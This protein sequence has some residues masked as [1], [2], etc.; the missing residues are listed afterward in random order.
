MDEARISITAVLEL[1]GLSVFVH[2][3][4][5]VD[6]KLHEP[7]LG[8]ILLVQAHICHLASH[9]IGL[10]LFASHVVDHMSFLD[11]SDSMGLPMRGGTSQVA[12]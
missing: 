11:L 5:L 1:A 9:D 12:P 8:D 2:E 3:L 7:D 4:D 6:G 10:E